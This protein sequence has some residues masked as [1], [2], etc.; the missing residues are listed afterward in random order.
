VD[1]I[2][3]YAGEAL[4]I[5]ENANFTRVQAEEMAES[6][7][8][9][10]GTLSALH[11]GPTVI[12]NALDEIDALLD[13]SRRRSNPM[14]KE[15]GNG[16]GNAMTPHDFQELV[17]EYD[18]TQDTGL[19]LSRTTDSWGDEFSDELV[20]PVGIPNNELRQD[21]PD[22]VAREL[23]TI[24][25]APSSHD[26]AI[27]AQDSHSVRYEISD[28]SF[29]HPSDR[30]EPEDDED[31]AGEV[32]DLVSDLQL[33]PRKP[34]QPRPNPTPVNSNPGVKAQ[35]RDARVSKKI[36]DTVRLVSL[37]PLKKYIV[38]LGAVTT[39][40][41]SGRTCVSLWILPR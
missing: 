20:R 23:D 3:D 12:R 38:T 8:P 18:L 35:A 22:T 19:P 7:T 5:S 10:E 39:C 15:R 9:S 34:I 17:R 31:I 27:P 1:S 16:N 36:V 28:E 33:T 32:T 6:D 4:R 30:E 11:R 24:R 40:S 21:F 29:Y 13:R 26:E 41:C 37:I 2:T 25:E 14:P